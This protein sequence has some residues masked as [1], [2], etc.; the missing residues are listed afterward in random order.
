MVRGAL[1]VVWRV[2][3]LECFTMCVHVYM[4]VRYIFNT[5]A[6]NT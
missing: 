3:S 6:R 2:A 5:E 4:Y 1:V